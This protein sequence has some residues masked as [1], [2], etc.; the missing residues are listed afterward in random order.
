MLM[1]GS[2][3]PFFFITQCVAACLQV[4]I[5]LFMLI[6]SGGGGGG[7]VWVHHVALTSALIQETKQDLN[8]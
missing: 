7:G 4:G 6:C 5:I 8:N 2:K 3:F 1:S